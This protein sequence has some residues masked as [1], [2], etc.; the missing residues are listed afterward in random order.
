V[1]GGIPDLVTAGLLDSR[2]NAATVAGYNYLVTAATADYTATATP[3]AT[4]SGRYGYFSTPDGVVRYQTAAS[5]NCF[6]CFPPGKG[7]QPVQ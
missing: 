1:Y 6:P 5:A 4:N 7:G 3:S 2:F